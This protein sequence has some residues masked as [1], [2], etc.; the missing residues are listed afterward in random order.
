MRVAAWVGGAAVLGGLIVLA[1]AGISGATAVLVT[2]VA[3]VVMVAL[4]GVVGGRR[5]P[6]VA[7]APRPET[8]TRT[9]GSAP[10]GAGAEPAGPEGSEGGGRH[11]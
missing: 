10:D 4:G 1:V 5:T 9:A 8:E 6:N 3:L 7:P 11:G 2:V